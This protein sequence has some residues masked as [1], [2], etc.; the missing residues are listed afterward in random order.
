[1]RGMSSATM[2]LRGKTSRVQV[3]LNYILLKQKRSPKGNRFILM[4]QMM[5]LE[6][7][8]LASQASET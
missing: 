1:M 2:F 4:V 5:G 7:T 3:P 6:P 8:R